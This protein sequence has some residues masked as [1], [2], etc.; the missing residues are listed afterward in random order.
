MKYSAAIL[1]VCLVCIGYGH[2]SYA[3]PFES[4]VADCDGID[5]HAEYKQYAGDKHPGLI[6]VTRPISGVSVFIDGHPVGT[7]PYVVDFDPDAYGD[8]QPYPFELRSHPALGENVANGWIK[9][10]PFFLYTPVTIIDADLTPILIAPVTTT[11]KI[12]LKVKQVTALKN[13][14]GTTTII[15]PPVNTPITTVTTVQGTTTPAAQQGNQQFTQQAAVQA[16]PALTVSHS[17][18]SSSSSSSSGSAPT[19]S[20]A[21]GSTDT[22]NTGPLSVTT[23]PAGV[24]IFIDGVQRGVSPATIPGLA[25]GEHT[26]L[27]KLDGYTDLSTPVSITAG[28]TTEYTTGMAKAAKSPGFGAVFGIIALGAIFFIRKMNCG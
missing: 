27:L 24:T 4:Y 11:T 13:L 12:P 6:I 1:L 26:L 20:A 23:T 15:I 3:L 14:T 16:S 22:A 9:K 10:C 18:S 2:G 5:S 8:G 7:T 28:K 17:G 25:P 19:S 21:T